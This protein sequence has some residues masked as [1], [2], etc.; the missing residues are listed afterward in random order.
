MKLDNFTAWVQAALSAIYLLFTFTV[1]VIYELGGAHLTTAGQEKTFDSMV[2]W[3]TGGALIVLYFWLQRAKA[4]SPPDT[5]RTV[6]T[7]TQTRT[8]PP[9]PTN[10]KA[11]PPVPNPPD[12][13]VLR[14][15]GSSIT[16]DV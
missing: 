10:A 5:E 1:I 6:I 16:P 14:E 15:S 12:A 7:S 4:V 9:E 2:N 8:D 11:I 3:M 13:G